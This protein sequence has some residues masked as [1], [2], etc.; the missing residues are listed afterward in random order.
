MNKNKI[1]SLERATNHGDFEHM[2][3]GEFMGVEQMRIGEFM[4]VVLRMWE[5]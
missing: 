2:R 3:I 4:G 1:G 5:R